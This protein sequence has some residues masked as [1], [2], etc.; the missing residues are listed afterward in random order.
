MIIGYARTSTLEQ[1]AGFTAQVRDLKAAGVEKV[2]KEQVSAIGE[3]PRLE[4]ALHSLRKG[5]QLV[6]FKLDRLARSVVHLGQIL[7]RVTEAGASLRILSMGVDTSTGTGRLRRL[8]STRVR[9]APSPT[10]G[11]RS[12]RRRGSASPRS[13]SGSGSRGRLSTSG[14]LRR[15][16]RNAFTG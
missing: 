9:S 2:F 16:Q 8:A 15:S 10:S 14:S 11:S 1:Q 5:D 4:A 6:V 13:P 7:K 3:R 12:C